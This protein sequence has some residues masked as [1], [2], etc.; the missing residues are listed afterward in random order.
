MNCIRTERF[1]QQKN[2][3]QKG[4][5]E[6]S[7]TKVNRERILHVGR[8]VSIAHRECSGMPRTL[9]RSQKTWGSEL[10]LPA[11]LSAQAHSLLLGCAHRL[12]RNRLLLLLAKHPCPVPSSRNKK[13][14]LPVGIRQ[15]LIQ[16]RIA[17]L[18]SIKTA[19]RTSRGKPRT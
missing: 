2:S 4:R 14:E 5:L 1:T 9:K 15:T 12:L 6:A 10:G 3:W 16:T 11:L 18:A 19:P 7:P 17:W 8:K 13:L